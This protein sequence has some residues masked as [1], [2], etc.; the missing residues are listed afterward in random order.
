[1]KHSIQWRTTF[2]VIAAL[3]STILHAQNPVERARIAANALGEAAAG[4]NDPIEA[5]DDVVLE[6]SAS[7]NDVVVPEPEAELDAGPLDD[8][9]PVEIE[10]A[11]L[12]APDTDV[13][14]INE[15]VFDFDVP[16]A[17]E[18]PAVE[19]PSE[20]EATASVEEASETAIDTIEFSGGGAVEGDGSA[21]ITISLDDVSLEDTVRMFS[22][23]SGANIIAA[24]NLFTG[25]VVSVNL[26]DVDWLP[27]L[28]SIL[29]I[30]NFTLVERTPGAGVFSVLPRGADAPEPAQI[31][32]FPLKYTT[33]GEMIKPVEEMLAPKRADIKALQ[34]GARNSLV[35]RTTEG[36]IGELEK[37]IAELDRPANQILIEVK[38]LELTDSAAK[39][40][41]VKWDF[42]RSVNIG[43]FG[44]QYSRTYLETTGY[45]YNR[46]ATVERTDAAFSQNSSAYNTLTSSD[47]LSPVPLDSFNNQIASGREAT[48]SGGTSQQAVYNDG[49]NVIKNIISGNTLNFILNPEIFTLFI[50]ALEETDGVSLVSNPKIITTSGKTD[51]FINIG[52][53][54]PILRR[55]IINPGE[56]NA[57]VTVELD[58]SLD[59]AVEN[60]YT[61]LP[62]IRKGYLEAGLNLTVSSTVKDND[63][64]EA[65]INPQLTRIVDYKTAIVMGE[66]MEWPI[67]DVKELGTTFT[68]K[69]G[70]TVAIGGLTKTGERKERSGVPILG[71]IP[72]LGRL[73]SHKKTMDDKTETIIFVTLTTVDPMNIQPHDAIPEDARLV[74]K[75]MLSDK[76]KMEAFKKELAALEQGNTG[77]DADDKIEQTTKRPRKKR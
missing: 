75:R 72:V 41:G 53:R 59:T 44:A 6:T 52:V 1:M 13:I 21:R 55:T 73:F 27:A 47:Q 35:V 61:S 39:E 15:P 3:L 26:I 50:S 56:S 10:L 33:T 57:Y 71:R 2:A 74:F 24:P 7:I 37:L 20:P 12:E 64:I 69:S 8:A 34:F 42:L 58:S 46:N 48:S 65:L 18:E 68:L 29:E 77:D 54:E 22:Q 30:H 31:R 4:G 63:F 43:S 66:I 36:N 11:P 17:V 60:K 62:V 16:E 9:A 23:T 5:T 32:V 49:Y 45:E 25:K 51:T 28:R 70:Q 76:A 38:I 67:I 40:V 19:E 14:E